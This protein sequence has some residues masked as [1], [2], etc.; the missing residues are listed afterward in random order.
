MARDDPEKMNCAS[1]GMADTRRAFL[2]RNGFLRFA[3]LP[4]RIGATNGAPD[5]RAGFAFYDQKQEP[6]GEAVSRT[7]LEDYAN[8]KTA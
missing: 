5:R 2:S 6:E 4:K 8:R 7:A 3:T 1:T